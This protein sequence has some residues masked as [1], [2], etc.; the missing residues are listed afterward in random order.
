MYYQPF[1]CIIKSLSGNL[2]QIKSVGQ[3]ILACP[4]LAEGLHSREMPAPLPSSSWARSSRVWDASGLHIH[5]F[6]ATG[7]FNLEFIIQN[8]ELF[9]PALPVHIR[10]HSPLHAWEKNQPGSDKIPHF[11]WNALLFRKETQNPSQSKIVP[12]PHNNKSNNQKGEC[13][14][15]KPNS[16]TLPT[17]SIDIFY[18]SMILVNWEC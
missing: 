17:F 7:H 18:I 2:K 15:K 11:F 12:I 4:E 10:C 3:T 8:L 6:D 13:N 16:S 14:P 9:P 1:L 5:Y